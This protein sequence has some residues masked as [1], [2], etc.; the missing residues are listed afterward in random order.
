M[1]LKRLCAFLHVYRRQFALV[2]TLMIECVRLS[3][4]LMK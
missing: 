3:H 4:D 2:V 1:W